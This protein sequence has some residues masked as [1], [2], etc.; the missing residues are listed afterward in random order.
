MGAGTIYLHTG[1][2]KAKAG[3]RYWGRTSPV[4]GNSG[5]KAYL[6]RADGSKASTWPRAS[7]DRERHLEDRLDVGRRGRLE[8]QVR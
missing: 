2:G 4:W 8:G 6:Y 3:H 7:Q 5:E 1:K